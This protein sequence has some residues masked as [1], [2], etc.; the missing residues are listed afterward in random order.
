MLYRIRRAT[1][2]DVEGIVRVVRAVYD[3]FGFTW[4]AKEYH[5]DL[6]DPESH[7]DKSGDQFLVAEDSDLGPD[8]RG[9]CGVVGLRFHLPIPGEIGA[10]ALVGGRVRASGSDC[11]LERLYVHPGA[12]RNGMGEALTSDVIR[13]AVDADKKVLELWSDKRFVDAHRLYGR[14]GAIPIGERIC[15]D[16]D[17]SPE[18][19]LA[20]KLSALTFETGS[21][22]LQ[23]SED[24]GTLIVAMPK[25]GMRNLSLTISRNMEASPEALYRAWTERFDQ[26]FAVPGSVLMKPQ[27]NSVFFFQTQFDGGRHPHYGR[28]LRLRRDR[29][30]E[31]TWV[32]T[33]TM[34][35]ETIVK[36][37]LKSAGKRT[38]LRLTHS[39]FPDEDTLERHEEA[40]PLVLEQLDRRLMRART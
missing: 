4:D 16:P 29:L 15:H 7:Y 2:D 3:E 14:F 12:R 13:R 32:T 37:E 8:K 24:G 34:G 30:V 25:L 35:H 39:G 23:S 36:V 26:W 27:V 31:L 38:T 40:W 20:I 22:S 1:N 11:S 19:G 6:Y 18:W 21:R 33:A 28:F 9:I 17:Q 10:T 5:A